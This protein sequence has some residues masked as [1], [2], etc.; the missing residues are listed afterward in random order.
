MYD[1]RIMKQTFRALRE[2][3]CWEAKHPKRDGRSEVA[4]RF[5]N[6]SEK[7]HKIAQDLY[8]QKF[9]VKGTFSQDK[10]IKNFIKI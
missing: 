2:T 9:R 1:S 3:E 4:T 6:K 8:L 10:L 5:T 7:K